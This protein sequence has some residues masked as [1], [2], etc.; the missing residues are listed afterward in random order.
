MLLAG[1]AALHLSAQPV[2]SATDPFAIC[3][4]DTAHT[5]NRAP[6]NHTPH[7]QHCVACSVAVAS[8]AILPT[9]ARHVFHPTLGVSIR[10]S[11]IA[12]V[13]TRHFN[14]KLSQGPPQNA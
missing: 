2:P 13:S 4:G 6:I 3:F 10:W 7:Q 8:P 5:D 14:P 12:V 1:L 11:A 9:I